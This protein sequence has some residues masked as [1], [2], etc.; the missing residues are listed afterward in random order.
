MKLPKEVSQKITERIANSSFKIFKERRFR[1]WVDFNNLEQTEQ[2]RIFNELVVTG[3]SLAVLMF[4]TAA[5]L[6]TGEKSNYLNELQI[7][8]TSRYGNW[9]KELG[10][11]SKCADM[12]KELINMR[13]KE[14]EKD[15]QR[16]KKELPDPQKS[17]PWIPVVA[18]GG[19]HH[20]RRGK[21]EERDPLFLFLVQWVKNLAIDI[22]KSV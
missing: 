21:T 18:F 10:T 11:E 2:D 13:C 14:Y 7:E 5:E 3:L 19:Y 4:K 8:L 12:W 1:M 16:Y 20:I 9:L 15:F 17:N 22:S 6:T